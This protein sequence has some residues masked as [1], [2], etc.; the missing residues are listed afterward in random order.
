MFRDLPKK[1]E[2]VKSVITSVNLEDVECVTATLVKTTGPSW[3]VQLKRGINDND[4]NKASGI[5]QSDSVQRRL[6]EEAFTAKY[7]DWE[8]ADW[9]ELDWDKVKDLRVRELL[10]ERRTMAE[11]AQQAHC[12]SCPQFLKHVSDREAWI[13]R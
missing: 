1:A 8:S 10:A 3:N 2:E 5:M 7:S 12:L 13:K 11:I 4:E 9:N 6:A